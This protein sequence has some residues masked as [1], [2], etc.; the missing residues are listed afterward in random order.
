MSDIPQ[1]EILAEATRLHDLQ[2]GNQHCDRK[3]L[4]SCPALALAIFE[5]ANNIRARRDAAAASLTTED[6]K[7]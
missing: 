5:A 6:S 2:L 1:D 3:Y 4:L 7:Q